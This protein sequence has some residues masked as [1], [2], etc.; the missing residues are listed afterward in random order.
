M[1]NNMMYD[2]VATIIRIIF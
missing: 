1:A 2:E